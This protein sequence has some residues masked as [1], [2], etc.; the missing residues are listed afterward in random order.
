MESFEKEFWKEI[1]MKP[2]REIKKIK[3]E[4]LEKLNLIEKLENNY[5]FKER[6]KED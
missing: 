6:I 5:Y 1:S 3:K 4:L 2:K